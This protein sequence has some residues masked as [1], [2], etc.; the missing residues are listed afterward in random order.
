MNSKTLTAA[1]I[2]ILGSAAPLA[3]LTTY[4]WDNGA[5]TNNISTNTNWS[6]DGVPTSTSGGVSDTARWDG[7][8]AGNL[9]LSFSGAFGGSAGTA[10][11]ILDVT[12]SQTGNL[13][14]TGNTIRVNSIQIAAGAGAV[15]LGPIQIG[16]LS[17]TTSHSI[18]NNNSNG[19]TQ[20]VMLKGGGGTRNVTISGSGSYTINGRIDGGSPTDSNAFNFIKDGSGFLFLN[21]NSFEVTNPWNSTLTITNGVVRISNSHALGNV[22][23]GSVGITTI[24]SNAGARLELTGGI[25]VGETLDIKGKSGGST[26][27]H[28]LNVSGNNSVTGTITLNTGGNDYNFT[29]T[30]GRMTLSSALSIGGGSTANKNLRIAGAGDIDLT[31][32]LSDGTG[33]LHLV[34]NDGGT[35]T[36]TQAN[37]YSG[38]T[39]VQGGKLLV[40]NSISSSEVKATNTGTRLASDT[41]ATIGKSVTMQSGTI[42]APG[43]AAAVGTATVVNTAKFE[44]QSI[45]EWDLATV[46]NTY[47]KLNVGSLVGTDAVFR[48]VSSTG[49]SNEFWNTSRSWSDIFA[50][51]SGDTLAAVFSIIQGEGITSSGNKGM[52]AGRG[53]F[54]LTGNTLEWVAVP[55]PANGLV[56]LLIAAGAA[57]RRRTSTRLAARNFALR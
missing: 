25:S 11:I 27:S 44:S 57:Q 5:G 8:V 55:E 48:I 43:D 36:L 54:S 3:A 37:T 20:D 40:T 52:V 39:T 42:L 23:S 6:P 35:L 49:F 26:S 1:G 9:S 2:I 31:G 53:E 14:M 45:F 46:T 15:T 29:S 51:G 33:T 56:A 32:T 18:T 34:K 28:L 7:S 16:G 24:S 12:S 19:A 10:G 30:G 4:I 13:A 17:S 21:G 50:I 47:D 41:S 38:T 22:G